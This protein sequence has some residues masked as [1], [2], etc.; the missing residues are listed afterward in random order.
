[1]KKL[2]NSWF[3]SKMPSFIT[4]IPLKVT[5]SQARKLESAFFAASQIYN[6]CLGEAMKRLDRMKVDPQYDIAREL[7]GNARKDKY[8][9]L[10]KQY[11]FSE[12][13][14][15]AY[16]KQW[17]KTWLNDQLGVHVIQKLA[18]RAFKA[19]NDYSIHLH[20]KPRFKGLRGIHSIE[21]KK[22]GANMCWKGNHLFFSKMELKAFLD[23]SDPSD[24]VIQHGLSCKVKYTRLVRKNI[25]GKVRYYCQL[26]NEGQS[27]LKPEHSISKHS[28]GLDI[29]PSTIAIVSTEKKQAHLL[30]FCNELKEIQKRK[31]ALQRQI[32]RQIRANNPGGFHLD[33]WIKKDKHWKRKKGV[34]KK[35]IRCNYQSK[36]LQAN[37]GKL[38]EV[39]RKLAAH[40]KSLHGKLAN[41]I[42]SLGNNIKTEKLS[43]KSFQK[44]YGKSVGYRAP[45]MFVYMLCRKAERA[46][47]M[48][49]Q[50]STFNTKLSQTC[51]CGLQQ[52]KRLSERWHQ[53]NCGAQ[54]QR[55]LYSAY[56]ACFVE[57]DTLIASNAAKHWKGMDTCLLSAINKIKQS[58]GK[59]LPSSFGII[60]S[61]RL[62]RQKS[63]MNKPLE[64]FAEESVVDYRTSRV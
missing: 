55:D 27:F 4:E 37:F 13:A 5:A 31:A 28:V 56:L 6:A 50:F 22:N 12:Y 34:N 63:V 23:R 24:E 43:Y 10:R 52:K 44:M 3:P 35:G 40:R 42:L 49:E 53:C 33:S 61:K 58:N 46:G 45:G 20:G 39:D 29:G 21:N 7:K 54:A 62:S 11:Q 9:T 51:H 60:Q 36:A 2:N 59:A 47:G 14:L 19:V 8:S 64:A 48:V 15:H 38:A 18:T 32:S 57:N 16:A 41:D 25:N 17:T 1:M 26:I 30:Q